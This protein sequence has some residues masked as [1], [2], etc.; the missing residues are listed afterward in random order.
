MNVP[1]LSIVVVI[2]NMSRE[3]PRTLHSLS[4]DYQLD[5]DA[6]RYEVI[7]VDNRSDVPFGEEAVKRQGENFRYEYIEDASRS[8]ASA[9]NRGTSL[10][11]GRCLGLMI[12]GARMVTPGLISMALSVLDYR[13]DSMVETIGFHLGPDVQ[14]RSIE[15]GYDTQAEDDLLAEIDWPHDGYRLFDIAALAGSYG[16]GWFGPMNESN[17]LFMPS[18]AFQQLGGYEER[19]KEPGGDYVNLDFYLRALARSRPLTIR[20]LGEANF[21]QL[22]FGAATGLSPSSLLDKSRAWKKEYNSIRGREYRG[23]TNSPILYGSVGRAA[24]AWMRES[25]DLWPGDH[26]STPGEP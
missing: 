4:G 11:A 3:A 18:D 22:H 1:D 2:Y 7:V 13:G 17:C 14:N 26:E 12:D 9:M 10:A 5:V 20:L 8:P 6:D 19:F 25:A 15:I 23:P 24:A 16:S 21:H